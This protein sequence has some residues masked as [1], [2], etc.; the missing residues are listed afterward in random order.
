MQ[1]TAKAAICHK[2][3][4]KYVKCIVTTMH[5]FWK[6][7]LMV[8][9]VTAWLQKVKYSYLTTAFNTS[10][11]VFISNWKST[12]PGHYGNRRVLVFCQDRWRERLL[13]T[14]TKLGLKVLRTQP[15]NSWSQEIYSNNTNAQKCI[16]Y[17]KDDWK[18]G[19]WRQLNFVTH[20]THSPLKT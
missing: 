9:E 16:S 13:G 4:R 20:P 1:F 12:V 10:S 18:I 2:I 6:L 7:N 5:T 15:V 17:P 14:S 3:H 8:H 11:P 19:F